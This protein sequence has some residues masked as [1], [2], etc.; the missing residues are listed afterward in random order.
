[1]LLFTIGLC[2]VAG[3]I[4]ERACEG[5]V[6]NFRRA[7]LRLWLVISGIWIG[8]VLLGAVLVSD[9]HGILFQSDPGSIMAVALVPPLVL[10]AILALLGWVIAG[11]FT[12]RSN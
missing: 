11:L 9:P 6:M 7:L 8:G 10:R 2:T 1:M 5:H 12:P 3:R 4:F